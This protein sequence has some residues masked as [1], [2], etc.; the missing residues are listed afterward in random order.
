MGKTGSGKSTLLDLI[1]GLLTPSQGVISIDGKPLTQDNLRAWQAHIAHVPQDIYLSDGSIEDNIAFGL[2]KDNINHS[3]V[4]KAAEQAQLSETIES[5]PEKYKTSVGEKGVRLSGGQRQRIGI[6][7]ALYKEADVIVFDEATSALD[8][9]TENA[10][11]EE[12]KG[13][14]NELT[15]VIVAHRLTTMKYCDVIIE[16]GDKGIKR[17]GTFEELI[18]C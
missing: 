16:L 1:M 5:L 2:S 8:Y 6:A 17:I 15:V 12:I 11:I 3:L 18:G 10:I 9:A 4:R 7:R 14:G 13:L